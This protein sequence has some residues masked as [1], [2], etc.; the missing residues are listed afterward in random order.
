M[1]A[2]DRLEVRILV[3]NWIDM[4][5]P[6]V[7]GGRSDGKLADRCG[8]VHHFDPRELPPQAENGISFLVR[9]WRNDKSVSLLFDVGLT[10]TVLSHNLRVFREDPSQLDH[11]LISHGHPDHYGGITTLLAEVGRPIAVVTHP[12]AFLPRYAIMNE[13]QP[14]LYYNYGFTQQALEQAGARFVLAT[15]PV[16]LGW[17]TRTSGQIPREVEFEGPREPP[18]AGA[19]GLYQLRRDGQF[20]LDQVWDEQAL[21]VDVA[22]EGLVILTGCAHAGVVNTVRRSMQLFGNRPIRAVLGG[23]HLGFPTTPRENV[24][25]TV[26]A[27][28]EHG[29]KTVVPM[30]CSGLPANVAFRQDCPD[31]Y[32]QPSVGTLLTFGL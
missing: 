23:F 1:D 30:H 12:D 2:A 3:D 17:G 21:L 22:S 29:V 15:G 6:N 10:G 19:P 14:S 4:L 9:V 20:G 18:F 11:V 25:R 31:T 8:L 13:G 7:T 28:K 32:L 26:K 5:L 24:D 16:E 27:L